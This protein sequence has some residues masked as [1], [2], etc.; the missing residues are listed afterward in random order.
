MQN[1]I[2]ERHVLWTAAFSGVVVIFLLYGCSAKYAGPQFVKGGVQFSVKAP[3]A[4]KVSIA[5]SFNRWDIEKDVLAGP[6]EAG[7]WS[8]TIPLGE[9]RYEYL[10]VING[11]KWLIDPHGPFAAD[12]LGG[13]NSVVFVEGREKR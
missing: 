8:I 12:G 13:K 7:I 1:F 2:L 11:E 5:G 4:K 9:G 3:D 6:D 10:F